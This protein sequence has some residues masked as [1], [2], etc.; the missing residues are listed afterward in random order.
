MSN[1]IGWWHN[2]RCFAAELEMT[3]LYATRN[4]KCICRFSDTHSTIRQIRDFRRV[5]RVDSSIVENPG[6]KG[7]S[8]RDHR[9][10]ILINELFAMKS[11]SGKVVF[12]IGPDKIAVCKNFYQR[13]TG[14]GTFM[15]MIN[16]SRRVGLRQVFREWNDHFFIRSSQCSLTSASIWPRSSQEEQ[17]EEV[18]DIDRPADVDMDILRKLTK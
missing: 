17:L 6:F 7:L 10:F 9:N 11:S 12:K 14:F 8:G 18:F 3:F 4:S 2:N 1:C 15:I 16:V 13:C 5:L